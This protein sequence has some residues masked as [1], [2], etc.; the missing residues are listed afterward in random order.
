[1]KGKKLYRSLVILLVCLG[2]LGMVAQVIFMNI[3]GEKST[4]QF[5]ESLVD[6]KQAET[7]SFAKLVNQ[8]FNTFSEQVYALFSEN[9]YQRL[10]MSINERRY[11]S[12]YIMDAQY[13]WSD[14]QLRC[15]NLNYTSSIDLYLPTVGKKITQQSIVNCDEKELELVERLVQSD[16]EMVLLDGKLYFWISQ[17]FHPEKDIYQMGT[18]AVG[19]VD[20]SKLQHYLNGYRADTMHSNLILSMLEPDGFQFLASLNSLS[21]PVS[22]LQSTSAGPDAPTGSCQ[23]DIDGSACL[24]N[25]SRI[26]ST[27]VYLFEVTPLEIISGQ[28]TS[29]REQTIY[30]QWIILIVSLA[31]MLAV[32]CMV[33][34]PVR[35]LVQALK[36]MENGHLDT[37]LG[38]T[39]IM[40]FQYAFSSFNRMSQRIQT[41]VEKEYE[42]RLLHMKAQLRQLQYQI[43][44][45]F[46]YNTYF[47]LCA[48][49]DEEEVDRASE[50]AHLL[51]EYLKYITKSKEEFSSL[52]LEIAHAKNYAEIQQMRFSKRVRLEF[53]ECPQHFLQWQVP[54]LIVQPLIENA[55]EHGIKYRL[56]DGVIRVTFAESDELYIQVEDNGTNLSDETLDQL[57]QQ[58]T[59]GDG[60]LLRNGVALLN[61]QKRLNILYGGSGGL[62]V[63]RAELGG[64]KVILHIGGEKNV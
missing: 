26:G 28:L 63:E 27:H 11:N 15:L 41:L 64:L 58:L 13:I 14:L 35:K 49:L 32:Y 46:L 8:D 10:V 9:A 55:F 50:Y 44:P 21:N 51:G 2:M 29:Y 25:W 48:L 16:G 62:S 40:E 45:H 61:I 17:R 36:A 34:R 39:W 31:F 18:I 6:V 57:Q 56:S 7:N 52:E 42:L 5:W 38:K 30:Y 54:R 22:V 37:R 53:G 4:R 12:R 23:L 1:M 47:S 19:T 60:E 59:R 20:S 3:W 24:V 43:N 33:N